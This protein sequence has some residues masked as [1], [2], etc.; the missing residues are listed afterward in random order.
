MFLTK[1]YAIS[2]RHF[3]NDDKLEFIKTD[4]YNEL[5]KFVIKKLEIIIL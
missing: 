1:D 2:N 5:I 4:S 3:P